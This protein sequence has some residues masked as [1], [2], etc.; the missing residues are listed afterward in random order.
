L[1]TIAPNVIPS[2]ALGN[3]E[4]AH[5]IVDGEVSGQM[6]RSIATTPSTMPVNT[7]TF[8][9]R[10]NKLENRRSAKKPAEMLQ[11]GGKTEIAP[12]T[13]IWSNKNALT[14]FSGEHSSG[15]QRASDVAVPIID[16]KTLTLKAIQIRGI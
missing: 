7:L 15:V 12:V 16:S 10:R 9:E 1:E 5:S 14:I 2:N 13:K 4:F 8:I 11:R 3:A 6:D